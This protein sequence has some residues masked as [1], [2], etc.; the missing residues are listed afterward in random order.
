VGRAHIGLPDA[1][2]AG[3]AIGQE[4]SR[5]LLGQVKMVAEILRLLSTQ[6]GGPIGSTEVLHISR[7]VC[8]LV[9]ILM[10]PLSRILHFKKVP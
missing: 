3:D 7:I 9:F 4:A 2:D 5:D 8:A 1:G 10:T 6:L